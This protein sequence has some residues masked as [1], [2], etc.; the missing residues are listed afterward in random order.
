M[1]EKTFNSRRPTQADVARVAGVSQ[2]MVSYVL[3][4]KKIIPISP[5][6]RQRV[7]NVVSELGYEPDSA[8]RSLSMRKTFTLAGIIPDITNPFFPSFERGIQ[9]VTEASNYHL[10]VYNTDGVLENERKCIRF[11]RQGRVDGVIVVA[12]HLD[13][14]DFKP[15][16]DRNVAV[17]VLA[18]MESPVSVLPLDCLYV[19]DVAAASTAVDYLVKKGHRRVALINGHNGAP[20]NLNRFHGYVAALEG[21]NIPVEEAL[22]RAADYTPGEGY[23]A[24][25]ELLQLAERPTAVFCTNDLMAIGAMRAIH[26]A[27]LSIPGDIAVVGFDDVQVASMVTPTLTTVAQFQE[28]LG[29]VAAEMLFERLGGKLPPVPRTREM[30]FKLIVRESA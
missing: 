18:K 4:G 22:I 10:I 7:L 6:T 28:D 17:V 21:N 16:L 1:P 24:M 13:T 5:E 19:N 12:A 14:S 23:R 26:E 9:K 8:A 20:P 29:R 3:N 30:P 11:V 25:R 2:A 27:G 15:L